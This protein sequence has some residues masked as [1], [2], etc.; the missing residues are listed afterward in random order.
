M[1]H[2]PSFPPNFYYDLAPGNPFEGEP[3]LPGFL[4][5]SSGW[6][7]AE[8]RAEIEAVAGKWACNRAESMVPPS[9]GAETVKRIAVSMYESY[10]SR[11]LAGLP[12]VAPPKPKRK[13][14][15]KEIKELAR[16][17]KPELT[18]DIEADLTARI[19]PL[20]EGLPRPISIE[21]QKSLAKSIITWAKRDYGLT[22][23]EEKA[24]E[25]VKL[26]IEE[27]ALAGRK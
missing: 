24:A 2:W 16:V 10:R 8:Q 22:I 15:K 4:R 13:P 19:A 23:S 14:V 12:P 18:P 25:M 6:L 1:S 11:A 27:Y 20:L 5:Y 26:A 21:R 3:P 17:M 9:A 7:T